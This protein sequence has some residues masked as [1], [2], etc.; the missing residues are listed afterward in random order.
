MAKK[1]EN[2]ALFDLD[3]TLCDY[4]KG[5]ARAL[6]KIR[7]PNEPD[8]QFPIDHNSPKYIRER[9]NLITSNGEWWA[10][11]PKLQLGFDVWNLAEKLEYRIMILTQG[12][13]RN[14]KAW[15]GKKRWIDKHLGTELD[16]TITRDKSLVYGKVLVDDFPGYVMKWLV[17]RPRGLVIMPAGEV[18]KDFRHPQVIRYDGSNLKEVKQAMK[19]AKYRE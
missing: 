6:K 2:I 19:K 3:G 17:W 11:L 13:R 16:V 4:E 12:P 14:P 18:N 7:G 1:I 9:R 8:V 10:K 15:S 5:L